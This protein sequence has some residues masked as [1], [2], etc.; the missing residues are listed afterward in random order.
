MSK[1]GFAVLFKTHNPDVVFTPRFLKP[2]FESWL[3]ILF[4]K[5]PLTPEVSL[6]QTSVPVVFLSVTLLLADE[7]KRIEI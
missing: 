2:T 4:A 5:S 6:T 3:H 1:A 7:L